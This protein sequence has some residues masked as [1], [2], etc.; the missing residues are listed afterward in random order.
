MSN[1]GHLFAIIISFFAIYIIWG[2]TYLFVA[3]AVE[4]IP[5]LK[6]AAVRFILAS[7]IIFLL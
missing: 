6:M 7:T 2:S 4:E 1:K 3:Y 5:P